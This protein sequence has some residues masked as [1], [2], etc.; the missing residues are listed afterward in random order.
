LTEVE[1]KEISKMVKVNFININPLKLIF[2][3]QI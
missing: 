3:R 2:V 1:S